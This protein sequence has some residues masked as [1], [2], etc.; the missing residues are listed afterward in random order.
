MLQ[1]FLIEQITN[2]LNNDLN[3]IWVT[4]FHFNCDFL[5]SLIIHVHLKNFYILRRISEI[6]LR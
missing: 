4:V 6:A 1:I 5:F 2:P 3:G